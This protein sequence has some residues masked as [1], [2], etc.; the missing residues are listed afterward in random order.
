MTPAASRTCWRWSAKKYILAA[1]L[2][3]LATLAVVAGIS[4]S[5][6]PAHISFSI[7]SGGAITTPPTAN[8][9]SY[10]NFTVV[11][12]NNISSRTAVRY[13][14][15]SAQIWYSPTSWVP[16][17]PEANMTAAEHEQQPGDE[18]SFPVSAQ[19]S[20]FNV[21][22]PT[23]NSGG[24]LVDTDEDSS[25]INITWP[26]CKVVV[27]AKVWFSFRLVTTRQYTVRASC[28]PVDFRDNV[29]A[30]VNCTF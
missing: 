29:T 9:N 12:R 19:F 25:G 23:N 8:H 17:E 6:A 5:L 13:G 26:N 30:P 3:M 1:L 10:Y 18:I 11:A 20:E 15:L 27:E 14:S 28:Y 7:A 24:Q 22:A 21:V 4:I 2:G 16:A